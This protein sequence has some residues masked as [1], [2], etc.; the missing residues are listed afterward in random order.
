MSL[1]ALSIT[2]L[3]ADPVGSA[4]FYRRHF[5]FTPPPNWTGSSACNIRTCQAC[6]STCYARGT[7]R[8]DRSSVDSRPPG[9]CWP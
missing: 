1:T 8:P 5:G 4:R 9:S 3:S 6:T 7:R 2:V